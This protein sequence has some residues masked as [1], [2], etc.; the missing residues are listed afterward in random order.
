[1]KTQMQKLLE[2]MKPPILPIDSEGDWTEV[3]SHDLV[4]PIGYKEY[5]SIYGVGSINHFLWFFSPFATNA[6]L[7]LI[8]KQKQF[9]DLVCAIEE[10]GGRLNIM[11][12]EADQVVWLGVTDNG[13][14]VC[15]GK[16]RVCDSRFFVIDGRAPEFCVFEGLF[17]D[18]LIEMLSRKF[19]CSVFPDSF[20]SSPCNFKAYSENG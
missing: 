10:E 9:M 16:S 17:I 20:V 8:L 12:S 14:F 13:D 19:N 7:N 18:F 3:Q 11:L 6:D 5:I 4:L 15:W 2:M 1:M